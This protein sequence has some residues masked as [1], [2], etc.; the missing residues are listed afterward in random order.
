VEWAARLAIVVLGAL[1]LGSGL[2]GNA[3]ILARLLNGIGAAGAAAWVRT[4]WTSDIRVWVHLL[5]V[6]VGFAIVMASTL[7][8]PGVRSRPGAFLSGALVDPMRD[9]FARYGSTMI[10]ILALI[11]VYRI[12][13]FVLTVMNPF[14]LD[15]GFT[16]V[17][18]AEVRK[19]F[20]LLAT[21]AGVFAG[22]FAV[23]RFGVMRA[24]LAG[25]FLGAVSNLTF[26]WMAT[27]GHDLFALFVAIG[28]DNG[29]GGFA[30]TC[31]I[32][33][34]SG[35]TSTAFTAT[36]Y[37]LLSSLYAIPGRI[38]ASQ[39]GRV[40][41]QAAHA[42]ESQGM[43]SRL[44]GLFAS[45]TPE[46]FASAMDQSGV[47]PVSLGIGYVTFFAYSAL[48]GLLPVVLTLVVMRRQ[49]ATD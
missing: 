41:E 17:E 35:L 42:A 46:S 30:G 26:L 18:I 49:K 15:L 14:Y 11:C 1:L 4:L 45:M 13:D 9:F 48:I 10:V 39:S 5:A 3:D 22:G 33:Y 32:A 38:I 19:I 8:L 20:G 31:L 44:S 34:M 47:S 7:P 40:V 12:P 36:Q 27:R 21:M 28:I 16:L 6:L 29:S 2:T 25:A 37:A 23:A 24:L 43:L